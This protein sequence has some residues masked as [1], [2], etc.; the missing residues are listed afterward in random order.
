MGALTTVANYSQ[1]GL[2]D[3]L[4]SLNV[5]RYWHACSSFISDSGE[6]VGSIHFDPFP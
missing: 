6:T 4:P 5:G 2:V 1:S 3:Y